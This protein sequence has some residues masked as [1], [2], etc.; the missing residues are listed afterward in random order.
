MERRVT[1]VQKDSDCPA[2]CGR[3]Q[4]RLACIRQK[5]SAHDWNW[6]S[7]EE[8]VKPEVKIPN[9][10]AEVRDQSDN[11]PSFSR[12]P[13]HDFVPRV[14]VTFGGR[15]SRREKRGREKKG[16][17]GT[18]AILPQ[19]RRFRRARLACRHA[20]LLTMPSEHP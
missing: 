7:S 11:D 10:K 17:K 1:H 15:E 9:G 20:Y 4:V 18:D 19:G 5:Q 13:I 8:E 3:R 6:T 14:S 12:A 2:E 16:K